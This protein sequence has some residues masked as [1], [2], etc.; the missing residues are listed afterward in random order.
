MQ[1]KLKLRVI[2]Q[3][4]GIFTDKDRTLISQTKLLVVR[5]RGG[6]NPEFSR[7]VILQTLWVLNS[8]ES[9]LTKSLCKW[10]TP[11]FSFFGLTMGNPVIIILR[12]QCPRCLLRDN[13]CKA[14]IRKRLPWKKQTAEVYHPLQL[15]HIIYLVLLVISKWKR[16][17]GLKY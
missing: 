3:Y 17:K 14:S 16:V 2:V 1:I 10:H 7:F 5:V 12:F 8:R 6:G 15:I 13:K 9:F 11:P 4:V